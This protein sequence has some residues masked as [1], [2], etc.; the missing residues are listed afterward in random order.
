MTSP[1][2]PLGPP[3]AELLGF[4]D[5]VKAWK[6]LVTFAGSPLKTRQEKLIQ[7]RDNK[8]RDRLN[9]LVGQATARRT[10]AQRDLFGG[11]P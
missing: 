10:Q 3:P 1:W 4:P 8:I 5:L 6:E 2:G 11:M 7:A 9:A